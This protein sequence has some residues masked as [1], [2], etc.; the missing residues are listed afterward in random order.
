LSWL[1]AWESRAREAIGLPVASKDPVVTPV[2]QEAP[3]IK[4]VIIQ[5][6]YAHL[7]QGDPGGVEI[8]YYFVSSDGAVVMCDADGTPTKQQRQALKPNDDPHLIAGRMV[9]ARWV[10]A[11]GEGNFNRRLN[12]RPLG[13]A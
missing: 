7:D 2:R 5:T 10:Y 11:N 12:Y 8:G 1:D 13:I 6:S 3:V 4:H 9:R